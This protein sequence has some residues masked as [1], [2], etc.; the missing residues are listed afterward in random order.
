MEKV[1]LLQPDDTQFIERIAEKV[2][3]KLRPSFQSIQTPLKQEKVYLTRKDAAIKLG[4]S[5]P[6]IDQFVIDGILPKLGSG[7]RARFRFED[8]ENLFENLDKIYHKSRS[9]I[10][11]IRIKKENA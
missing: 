3:E 6:T 10:P 1:I 11:Y 4:V 7:K 8:V 9:K 2:A 5:T